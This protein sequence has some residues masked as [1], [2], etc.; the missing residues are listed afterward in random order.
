MNTKRLNKKWSEVIKFL[1]KG[2]CHICKQPGTDAHHLIKRN[3][4]G[5]KYKWNPFN[6]VYLCRKCHQKVENYNHRQNVD[7]LNSNLVILEWYMSNYDDKTYKE[8]VEDTAMYWLD[9]TLKYGE[10][11]E[12][13]KV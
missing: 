12:D 5:L 6:G 10:P 3:T 1:F 8:V 11:Y 13:R 9:Y 4:H 7:M 2:K